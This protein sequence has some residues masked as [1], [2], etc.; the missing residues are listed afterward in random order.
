MYGRRKSEREL[1]S[2]FP[3]QRTIEHMGQKIEVTDNEDGSSVTH[4]GGPAGDLYSDRDG[5]S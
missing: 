2:D 3:K 4:F 1:P 5:N